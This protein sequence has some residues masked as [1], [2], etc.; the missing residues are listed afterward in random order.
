MKSMNVFMMTLDTIVQGHIRGCA[1]EEGREW[2]QREWG[3]EWM[4]L[5]IKGTRALNSI[6]TSLVWKEGV[7]LDHSS[8]A[9]M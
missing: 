1:W 9:K 5:D 3:V 2:R 6:L 8:H 4:S 7:L